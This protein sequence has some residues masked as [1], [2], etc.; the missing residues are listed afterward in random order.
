MKQLSIRFPP[1]ICRYVGKKNRLTQIWN[2]GYPN[3]YFQVDQSLP[4]ASKDL[5]PN[6][7]NAWH[8][9]GCPGKDSESEQQHQ[10]HRQIYCAR[11][12]SR[13]NKQSKTQNRKLKYCTKMHHHFVFQLTSMS[14]ATAEKQTEH[15][16]KDRRHRMARNIDIMTRNRWRANHQ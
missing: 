11:A 1:S 12:C 7:S 6:R 4:H 15:C 9:Q 8:L 2:A 5:D 14:A 3:H 13:Q 10:H 16:L